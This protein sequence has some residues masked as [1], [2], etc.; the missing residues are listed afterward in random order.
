MTAGL[1]DAYGRAITY[2]RISL[3][4][5]C[6]FRCVYCMSESMQ[7]LPRHDLLSFEEIVAVVR[8]LIPAGLRKVRLTGGEPLLRRDLPE[9]VQTLAALPGLQELALTTNGSQ[10]ARWATPLHRAGLNSLNISLDSLQA[11]RFHR[12]TRSGQLADVLVGIAAAAALPWV[13]RRL[14]ALILRGRN[15]DEIV[16]L[17]EFAEAQGFDMAYIEEMPLGQIEEHDRAL[18]QVPSTEILATLE[19][20]WGKLTPL[21]WGSGG[22]ARYFQRP[23][24]RQ[25]IG[26]ISPHSHNFCDDCNRVRL[27]AEGRLLLCLGQEDA[28][29]LRAVL[30]QQG[31]AAVLPAVQQAL[32]RKPAGHTFNLEQ[33]VQLRRHMNMTGG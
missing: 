14:N 32:Q 29:D 5:R 8:A 9:L 26:L 33:P 7:F 31:E 25:R 28:L 27:T 19:Q 21:A 12:L 11:E 13:R 4:D 3:T 22:P 16:A 6:D 23:G 24:A 20:A 18:Q 15:D 17:A 1:Q 30:R 10:L 2:L